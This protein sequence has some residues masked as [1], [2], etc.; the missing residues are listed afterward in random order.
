MISHPLDNNVRFQEGA[1]GTDKR[2]TERCLSW[3]GTC[4]ITNG[5]SWYQ[6]V[7]KQQGQMRP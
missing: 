2:L 1:V 6:H 4:W 7:H 5:G 3:A